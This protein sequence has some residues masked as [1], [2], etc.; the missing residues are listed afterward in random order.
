MQ[1]RDHTALQQTWQSGQYWETKVDG[2]DIW[3]P[4]RANGY[5]QPVWNK[6]QD[7]RQAEP[8]TVAVKYGDVTFVPSAPLNILSRDE[9][10]EIFTHHGFTVKEG[11][12]DLKP[13]VYEAAD[14]LIREVVRRLGR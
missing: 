7:Y 13:Y 4:V 14:N 1:E 3:V 10:R 8:P 6:Y 11:Q 5:E 12:T 2:S 9:V